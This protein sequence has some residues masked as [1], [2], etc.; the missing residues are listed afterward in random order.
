[1][2]KQ[3][4][5]FFDFHALHPEVFKLFVKF[6]RHAKNAGHRR[7]S[8]WAVMNQV[9]WHTDV[10]TRLPDGP[11]LNNGLISHYTRM[12]MRDYPE[13]KRFFHIKPLQVRSSLDDDLDEVYGEG[14]QL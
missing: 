6:S 7:Y 1:M 3:D 12:M 13:Y 5:K 2:N 14:W 4:R 10:T 9:R 8:G 11:R